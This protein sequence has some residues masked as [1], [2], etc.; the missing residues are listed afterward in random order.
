MK[1]IGIYLLVSLATIVLVILGVGSS[2]VDY[3]SLISDYTIA[4]VDTPAKGELTFQWLGNTNVLI[5]DGETSIMTDAWFTR[6]SLREIFTGLNT[7]MD[8][9][10]AGISKADIQNLKAIIPVHSH[11]DHVMDAPAVAEITGAVIYGSESSANVGRGWG[12]PEEQ[13]V[14]VDQ[15]RTEQFGD[16]RV[17]LIKSKHYEFVRAE[18]NAR[19]GYSIDAPVKQPASLGDY[20]EGGAYAVWIQHPQANI[21]I[22]GSC[23]Y[24]E[25]LLKDV[26]ADIVFLGVAGIATQTELYQDNYWRE[27]VEYSQAKT[28]IPIHWDSLTHQLGDKPQPP[29]QFMDKFAINVDMKGSVLWLMERDKSLHTPLMPLWQKVSLSQLLQENEDQL[30]SSLLN[31][32]Q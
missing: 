28:I 5:S 11:Y 1:K 6:P 4:N 21:L 7:D 18:A 24:I 20:E 19:A 16:F 3:S 23:G 2:R 22:N 9:V 8:A 26:R 30:S 12:L 10:K 29:S 32:G 25:G 31:G 14:V 17:T 15:R 13:L 27:V